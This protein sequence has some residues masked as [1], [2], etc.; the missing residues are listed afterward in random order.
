MILNAINRLNL[1]IIIDKSP[2]EFLCVQG[3]DADSCWII[4]EGEIE[5]QDKGRTITYRNS[6]EMIGEQ[7]LLQSPGNKIAKARRSAD[8]IAR[9]QTRLACID[10]AFQE[11]LTAEEKLAWVTTLSAVINEKL[12]QATRDR[13]RLQSFIY[14]RDTLLAR[15]ADGHALGL[16]KRAI[17]EAAPPVQYRDVI[18]WFSDIASFSAWSSGQSAQETARIIKVLTGIQIDLI[19]Q[20]GGQV[21]KLIGDG[22]MAIWFIDTEARR[23]SNPRKAIECAQAIVAKVQAALKSE[24][25]HDILDIRIGMHSGRAAYGDFGA[26]MRIA[27]TVLGDTVNLAARYEQAKAKGLGRIRISP[28]L[29]ELVDA[30]SSD[31]R[32]RFFGPIKAEVKHDLVLDIFWI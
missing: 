17:D 27:V 16:V 12:E 19:R 26:K 13:A 24:E 31:D 2:G 18:V 5:V 8:L 15:F 25:L 6:G 7:A 21:D 29:K 1:W 14:D 10:A 23:L 20:M 22:V 3:E 9:S 30:A 32:I 11:E 28:T 4:L